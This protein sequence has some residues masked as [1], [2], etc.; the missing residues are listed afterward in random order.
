MEQVVYDSEEFGKRLKAI[1]KKNKMTQEQLADK[2][3]LTAESVS[4][5]ENGK[6]ICMPEHVT[7]ICQIFNISADYFFFGLEKELV[8]EKS[9]QIKEIV[10]ILQNCDSFDLDKIN[11]MIKIM[12]QTK[13]PAA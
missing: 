9:N 7:Q 8:P 10:S 2:L 4:R 3:I 6:G 12:L 5:I 1:R 13:I 11:S